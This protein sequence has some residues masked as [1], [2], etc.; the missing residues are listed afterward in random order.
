MLRN[1]ECGNQIPST[2]TINGKKRNLRNRTKCLICLPFGQSRYRKKTPTEK[3]SANAKKARRHYH[4]YKEKLGID[5]I[6]LRRE[7]RKKELVAALGGKCQLCDYDKIIR[8]LAF[9]HLRDKKFPLSSRGFQ[10]SE[11]KIL[12][13]ASKCVLVCHNCHGEIHEGLIDESVLIELNL[14]NISVLDGFHLF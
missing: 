12:L 4:K 14:V 2:K 10:Y 13:E 9:H 5:P 11:K 1:C 3:R 6:R 7:R 8:N